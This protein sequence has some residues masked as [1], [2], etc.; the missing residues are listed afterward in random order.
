M[1]V[2]TMHIGVTKLHLLEIVL[3]PGNELWK[4]TVPDAESREEAIE[5]V[6]AIK[7]EVF[8]GCA[9]IKNEDGSCSGVLAEGVEQTW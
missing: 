4:D 8:C 6:R 5:A 9:C 2:G 7:T 3:S 1:T